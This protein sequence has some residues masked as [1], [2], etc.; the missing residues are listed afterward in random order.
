MLLLPR[1]EQADVRVYTW[2]VHNYDEDN[3]TEQASGEDEQVPCF[4]PFELN[5]SA[6]TFI[7][8]VITHR[9][10]AKKEEC[11]ENGRR[12]DEGDTSPKPRRNFRGIR[13]STTES[14]VRLYTSD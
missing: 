14:V 11:A 12:Y 3:H 7:N 9:S 13:I 1:D 6:Y 5:R 2:H 10:S 8:I 4:Q